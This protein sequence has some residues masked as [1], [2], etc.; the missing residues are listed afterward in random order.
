MINTIIVHEDWQRLPLEPFIA[1]NW[2]KAGLEGSPVDRDTQNQTFA[3]VD[4]GRWIAKCLNPDCMGAIVVSRVDSRY[5]CPDCGSPENG[6]LWYTVIWPRVAVAIEKALLERP[7]TF[8]NWQPGTSV[9]QLKERNKLGIWHRSWTAPIT[10]VT[11]K[12]VTASDGNEQWRDNLLETAP[13]KVT[14]AGDTV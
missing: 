14:T 12:S 13:A 1:A 11:G 5:I 8:R 6:G 10:W 7:V 3:E 9:A 4:H 2:R